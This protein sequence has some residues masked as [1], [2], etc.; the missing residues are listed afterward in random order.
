[1]RI[2]YRSDIGSHMRVLIGRN[3]RDGAGNAAWH[4]DRVAQIITVPAELGRR[5]GLEFMI[6][7]Y[8]TAGNPA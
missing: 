5:G 1:V 2:R 8:S 7:D 3:V 6:E 4:T